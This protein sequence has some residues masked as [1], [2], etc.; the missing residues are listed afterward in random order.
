MKAGDIDR[1][2]PLAGTFEGRGGDDGAEFADVAGPGVGGEAAQ[3][4]GGE[5]A[6]GPAVVETPLAEKETGEKGEIVAAVP[7]GRENETDGGEMA[8][9]IEAKGA[10]GSEAAQRPG[11]ADDELARSGEGKVAKALVRDALKEVA[12]KELLI[13]GK[14]VDSGKIGKA[15]R[16]VRPEGLRRGEEVRG[17]G[18]REGS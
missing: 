4:A 2:D 9:E 6:E 14:F 13:G 17:K 11:G 1:A 18:R 7:Q 3:R 16:G 15:A 10:C 8:G 12:E 5:A